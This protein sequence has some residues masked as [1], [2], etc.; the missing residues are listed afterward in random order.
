MLIGGNALY[1]ALF[2]AAGQ[3]AI[4]SNEGHEGV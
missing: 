1:T 3:V 4:N 2:A